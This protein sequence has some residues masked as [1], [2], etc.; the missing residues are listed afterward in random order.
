MTFSHS[1]ESQFVMQ[2]CLQLLMISLNHLQGGNAI[3]SLTYFGA[4]MLA[5]YT[6]QVETSLHFFHPWDSFDSPHYP[7]DSPIHLLNSNDA[8]YSFFRMKFQMSHTYSLMTYLS[9]ALPHNILIPMGN[10]RPTPTIQVSADLFGNMQ[11]MCIG[12]CIGSS[13]QV[14]QSHQPRH[15][16]VDQKSSL[17]DR[18]VRLRAEFQM[19]PKSQK[20]S[21]G[22]HSRHHRK[23]V[24]LWDYVAQSAFGSRIIHFLHAQSLNFGELKRSLFGMIGDNLL[25]IC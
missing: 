11:L 22:L 12:F 21:I 8:C 2:D 5:K 10:Q 18:S 20:F 9:K 1:M 24:C 15:K 19:M 6:L 7:L 16:F 14:P 3:Q 23:H 4:L 13:I 25:L 17:L